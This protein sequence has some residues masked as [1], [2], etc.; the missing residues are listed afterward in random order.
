MMD[1]RDPTLTLSPHLHLN[2]LP[3]PLHVR[4]KTR[5]T[6]FYRRILRKSSQRSCYDSLAFGPLDDI[7]SEISGDIWRSPAEQRLEPSCVPLNWSNPL[8]APSTCTVT[9]LPVSRIPSDQPLTVRKNRHS[10]STAS[11]S[12]A[13]RTMVSFSRDSSCTQSTTGSAQSTSGGMHSTTQWPLQGRVSNNNSSPDSDNRWSSRMDALRKSL[14]RL[15]R[16]DTV[17]SSG[18][19]TASST[20]PARLPR[21]DTADSTGSAGAGSTEASNERMDGERADHTARKSVVATS[22]L[23]TRAPSPAEY[24]QEEIDKEQARQKDP[25]KISVLKAAIKITPEENMLKSV[26][27][28]DFWAAVEITGTLHN[29]QELP[30]ATIDVAIIIDNSF[31]V[32]K[33][34]HRQALAVVTSVL[35]YLNRGDRVAVFATHCNHY[36]L[37]TGT[38][39]EILYPLSDI[40][41]ETQKTVQELINDIQDSGVQ[42][43]NPPRPNPTMFEVVLAVAKSLECS[44]SRADRTHV[45][46]LSPIMN[47]LHGISATFP[48]LYVHQYNPSVL[49]YCY[50]GLPQNQ[51]CTDACCSNLFA[52]NYLYHKNPAGTMRQIIRN[53]RSEKP[54]GSIENMH[55]DIKP[56]RGCE[57][58]DYEGSRDLPYLRLGQTYTFFVR[59]RVSP[60]ATEEVLL[61]SKDPILNSS[62]NATFMRQNLRSIKAAG[63]SMAHLLAVQ[64]L[65][66]SV[67]SSYETWSFTES[68]LLVFKDQG[69]MTTPSNTSVDYFK[70][71]L[72]YEFSKMGNKKAKEE[73]EKI[74]VSEV[75]HPDVKKLIRNISTEIARQE[76]IIDYEINV[77]KNMA[78]LLGPVGVNP[79]HQWRLDSREEINR[80]RRRRELAAE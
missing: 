50:N 51:M 16:S 33:E 35:Q 45:I 22:A 80:E 57:V 25:S 3:P 15:G 79:V 19:N 11:G 10:R 5:K 9:P 14:K 63:G 62:L 21:A 64:L 23:L 26:V 1:A 49:P 24:R 54:G 76:L 65:H 44:R 18:S 29:R 48:H 41:Q 6:T 70:R 43:W 60:S 59:L 78:P 28:Q 4:K 27:E 38:D 2:L 8:K 7:I 32:T 17:D 39:P 40:T 53:A 13:D 74:A 20:V 37:V 67:L 69:R 46:V 72:F 61:D 73:I 55:V 66:Q 34:C 31:Y 47:V 52:Y 36:G 58:L 68:Q 56:R 30:D 42:A 71:R 77:R 12:S 75:N